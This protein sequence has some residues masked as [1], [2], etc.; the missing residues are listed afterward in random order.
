M[1]VWKLHGH[2]TSLLFGGPWVLEVSLQLVHPDR[3][4]HLPLVRVQA[5]PGRIEQGVVVNEDDE[6]ERKYENDYHQVR[7]K[8]WN[9]DEMGMSIFGKSRPRMNFKQLP[10]LAKPPAFSSS[11]NFNI[12]KLF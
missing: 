1:D 4:V 5:T 8:N 10:F 11:I 7:K 12:L 6:K 9:E 3:V 2:M